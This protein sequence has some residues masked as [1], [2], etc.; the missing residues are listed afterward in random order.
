MQNTKCLF[1]VKVPADGWGPGEAAGPEVSPLLPDVTTYVLNIPLLGRS[2]K[3]SL[4]AVLIEDF[5]VFVTGT[6]HKHVQKN[7]PIS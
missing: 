6:K 4:H 2:A 3:K 1:G 5:L 7:N